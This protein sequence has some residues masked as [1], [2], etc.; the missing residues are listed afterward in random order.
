MT[1][2]VLYFWLRLLRNC[3]KALENGTWPLLSFYSDWLFSKPQK[4][5]D[6]CSAK[7]QLQG[8]GIFIACW[9]M[10]LTNKKLNSAWLYRL[11]CCLWARKT[12]DHLRPLLFTRTGVQMDSMPVALGIPV[13]TRISACLV[14]VERTRSWCWAFLDSVVLKAD[15]DW[16]LWNLCWYTQVPCRYHFMLPDAE[17]PLL[18]VSP[19]VFIHLSDVY[20]CIIYLHLYHFC[21]TSIIYLY[22]NL[23]IICSLLK[24]SFGIEWGTDRRF[25]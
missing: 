8:Q 17:L 11:R 9:G 7:G 4:I 12:R 24:L 21:N 16:S 18:S 14:L 19:Y 23:F 13:S 20:L 25:W 10:L 5:N 2:Q 6:A 22:T 3:K 1:C 15:R